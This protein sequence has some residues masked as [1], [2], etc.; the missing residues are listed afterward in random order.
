MG[1][2][3]LDLLLAAG[4]IAAGLCIASASAAQAQTLDADPAA[5]PAGLDVIWRVDG[6]YLPS[7]VTA[8]SVLAFSPDGN[9]L[10]IGD[11][12]GVRV[13]RT[14]DGSLV[15]MFFLGYDPLIYALAVSTTGEIAVGR[16]G[17]V[18]L[19][20]TGGGRQVFPYDCA[21]DCSP[22]GA[23]A[24]S[25]NAELLAFQG[26]RSGANRRR[27]LGSVKVVDV[28]T[29]TVRAELPASAARPRV[30]FSRD[31]T[32]LFAASTTP[33]NETESFGARGWTIADWALE[34]RLL[35]DH[36]IVRAEGALGG[37]EYAAA[38]EHEGSLE[39]EDLRTGRK[40]WS[41]G[42]VAP[43]YELAADHY[44]TRLERIEITGES[45]VTYEMPLIDARAT[46]GTIVIRRAGDGAAIG[47]YD[48][49]NVAGL[50][51]APDGKTFAY[52]TGAG[53]TYTVL[54]RI[55]F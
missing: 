16:V 4:M 41:V 40:L 5:I 13:R 23:V 11:E 42:L 21:D 51:V 1:L 45:V 8:S 29:G 44:T 49:P 7:S 15:E 36:R 2:P 26:R 14:A 10:A 17:S 9:L 50:A 52:A 48:V 18:E 25:P 22:V 24:F 32:R 27:G 6:R 3:K 35:G 12:T 33:F 20:R 54:A 47:L 31:G 37:T 19:H 43:T 30:A 38:Y 39:V 55:G 53:K 34:R 28:R 46:V